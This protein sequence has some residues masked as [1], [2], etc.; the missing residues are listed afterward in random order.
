[1]KEEKIMTVSGSIYS[2]FR[3]TGEALL[4]KDV[5]L[6]PPVDPANIV[7]IGLNYKSHAIETKM[8]FPP[9]PVIFIKTTN[10]ITG[11]DEAIVLPKMAPDE[12]DYEA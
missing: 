5:K 11:P 10:T 1:M 6:L 9:A 12:V 7:A 3:E 4:L 8:D 2:D